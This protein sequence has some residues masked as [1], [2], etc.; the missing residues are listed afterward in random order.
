MAMNARAPESRRSM[1]ASGWAA[2]AAVLLAAAAGLLLAAYPVYQGVSVTAT[3]SGTVTSGSESATLI[4]ENGVWAA[5]LLCIP[6]ALAGLGLVGARLLRRRVL[7]W[8][9][10][11]VLLGFVLLGSLS[12]GVFYLPAGVALLIAAALTKGGGAD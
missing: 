9:S 2:L 11:V 3:S 5:V 4:E 7:V 1:T 12:I 6:V 8:A 10:A